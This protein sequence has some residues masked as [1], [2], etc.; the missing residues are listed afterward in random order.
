ME[1]NQ[2]IGEHQ[3]REAEGNDLCGSLRGQQYFLVD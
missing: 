2:I 1:C 3:A